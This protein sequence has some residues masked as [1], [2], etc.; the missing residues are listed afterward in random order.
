L[1]PDASFVPPSGNYV[2]LV[3]TPGD[4]IGGGRTELLTPP[5]ST[6]SVVTNRTAA[7]DIAVG[8]WRGEF[9]GMNTLS[10]LE[11]GYYG[12]LQRVPFHNTARGGLNWTG[13]GRGCN[14]L[15]GWFVVDRVSYAWGQLTAIDLR[16]EQ[17]CEGG[18]TSQRG[19]IHWV[20]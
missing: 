1:K 12:D 3:S 5:T 10:Q 18:S 4:Y 19:V 13:N 9:V 11:P 17:F 6:M 7:L 8:G 14:T 20:K 16:F 2:F 15:K